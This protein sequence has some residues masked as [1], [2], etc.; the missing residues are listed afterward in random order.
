M[1]RRS[2][3]K[4]GEMIPDNEWGDNPPIMNDEKIPDNEW[5]DDP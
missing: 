1:G 5:G 2:L 3:I 4:N